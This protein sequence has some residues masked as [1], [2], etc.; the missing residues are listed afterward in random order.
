MN[1]LSK[2]DY[3]DEKHPKTK[4][5]Y[6]NLIDLK[7]SA[8]CGYVLLKNDCSHFANYIWKRIK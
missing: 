8:P 7:E 1:Y 5:N 3:G 2:E 6:Q 4:Y